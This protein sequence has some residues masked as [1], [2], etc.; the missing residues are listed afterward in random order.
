[1]PNHNIL[2]ESEEM[3]LV[4]IHKI[5]EGCT[6]TPIP[7]PKIAENLEVQPVSVN[8]MVKKLAEAGLVKYL[9][10]KGVELTDE[11]Q[12]ISTR[13]LRHRRL[14]EVFLVKDLK[15]DLVEADEL[16]CQLEHITSADVA[17][18]L[19]QYLGHPTVCFHGDPILQADDPVS[20]FVGMSMTDLQVGQVS[21]IMKIGG[22]GLETEFLSKEGIRLGVRLKILAIG[23]SGDMLLESPDGR[24]HLSAEMAAAITVGQPELAGKHNQE[25][26]TK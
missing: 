25:E 10:Y 9:P 5:C 18:R 19:S 17:N 1:M 15:M 24:I 14:W 13:I 8:Q 26:K 4:T 3:Y 2:S 11:G 12:A 6:D 22:S 23:S 20:V 7:I 16:A 21:S